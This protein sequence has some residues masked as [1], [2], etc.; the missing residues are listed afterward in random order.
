MRLK[1]FAFGLAVAAMGALSCSASPINTLTFKSSTGPVAGGVHVYPY[2][3]SLNGSTTTTPMMCIN[4]DDHVTQNEMWQ[5]TGQAVSTASSVKF[6]EDVW[7]FSQL[8]T[9]KYADADIQF[10]VWDVLDPGV[11]GNAGYGS[12]AKTLVSMAQ[13]AIP[14]LNDAFL[15]R[16]T[17]YSPVLTADAMKTW[18]DGTPQS[19]LAKTNAVTPEPSSLLLMVTGL[20]ATGVV[21]SRRRALQQ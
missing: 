15:N 12:V 8:G 2:N 11:G 6:Q 16:Y 14:G 1:N 21:V 5:V 4:Y 9:G 17:I 19:F 20:F 13:N 3:L 18:T 10:A 7:L